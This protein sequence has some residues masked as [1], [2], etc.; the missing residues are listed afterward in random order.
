MVSNDTKYTSLNDTLSAAGKSVFV[1][2]YYD[3][4]DA[5]ISH[6]V[7]A[8]KLFR[9]NPAT[10]S[11]RQGFRIPRARHIFE[12]GQQIEALKIVIASKKVDE[13]IK[14]LAKEILIKEEIGE[15]VK[16]DIE[17]EE[18]LCKVNNAVVYGGDTS[19]EYD[20]SPKSPKQKTEQVSAKYARSQRVAKNALMKAGNLCEY[21]NKH[22]VF[23]RRNSDKNYTEPH[24]IVPLSASAD[25]P[26]V[27]LDREQNVVSLCSNCHNILHY[28]ADF[29]KILK[30]LY[31]K[32]KDLLKSI[33][34]EVSYEEL[35]KYY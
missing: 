21:D 9:E 6:E 7:L 31:E 5:S 19:F 1:R 12:T 32:R 4:K 17:D 34:V 27:D 23:T 8:E 33:G 24:H 14:K 22:Y 13:E 16:K 11:K 20:N 26:N 18:F 3:F 30:P 28:G 2:F 10:I 25:F 29:E 15:I 35:K